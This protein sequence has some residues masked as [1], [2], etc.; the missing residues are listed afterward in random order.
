MPPS[1]EIETTNMKFAVKTWCKS[2]RARVGLLQFKT[3]TIETPALLLTTRKGLPA[4][5]SPDH[6]SFLPS[7]DSRLLQF[8]PMHFMEG[9]NLKTISNIGGVHQ[10]LGLQGYGFVAVPRDSIL[11]LPECY[12]S[13]KNGASFE[14]PCGR[15]LVKP[16]EYI[17]MI[18]SMKPDLWV[19]LADEVPASVTAKRNK[20]SVDRTITWLD[21][22]ISLKPKDAALFGSIVGGCSVEERKRCAQEV[23][24]RNVSGYYI[25]GFGLGDSIDERSTF[26]HAVTDSLPKEKPRQVCGLGLPEEVL[27][28]IAAGID[29]FDSTYI[30][31]LTLEG[32]ALVFPLNGMCKHDVSDPQLCAMASDYTKINLKATI[33]RKDASRIVDGCMCYTCQNHTKAYINH[34]L[35]VH[36]MLAQIL[37]E[38]HNTHHYLSFFRLIREAITEG[39]FE[40]F[41]QKFI[42]N[43]RGHLFVASLTASELETSLSPWIKEFMR[44]RDEKRREEL[45]T[46]LIGASVMLEEALVKFSKGK[47]FFG[48]DDIGYLDIVVGTF[49]G[50]FKFCGVVFNFN[51]IDEDRT[52]RMVEWGKRMWSNEVFQS[53]IPSHE[54]HRKF[55]DMLIDI[56]P[57]LPQQPAVSA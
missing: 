39:K 50:W 9:P 10:L 40:E 41:R 44:T 45:K 6:L 33:Y 29:L 48:G 37:L 47:P 4:F 1:K 52:P 46:L 57:P 49:L 28:G 22:C 23:A 15:F 51:V 8:S 55:L 3:T 19:S 36:E 21:D 12:S 13:N 27:Q 34:L 42:Q 38:I 26:L 30:Y 56:L 11:S 7:P 43:R 5:I 32:F 53:V 17:K 24:K 16:L 31:H 35:N 25:G 18:S 20:A 54:I 2:G 14:T